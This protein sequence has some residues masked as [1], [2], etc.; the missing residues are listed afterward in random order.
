MPFKS[1]IDAAPTCHARPADPAKVRCHAKVAQHRPCRRE[2]SRP[3]SLE[4]P[5]FAGD[6]MAGSRC[7]SH[8]TLLKFSIAAR[9]T[10]AIGTHGNCCDGAVRTTADRTCRRIGQQRQPTA[11]VIISHSF[12]LQLPGVVA[13]RNTPALRCH[14]GK[15]GPAALSNFALVSLCLHTSRPELIE[16]LRVRVS[17]L[18]LVWSIPVGICLPGAPD[19]RGPLRGPRRQPVRRPERY[20]YDSD[21]AFAAMDYDTQSYFRC[22]CQSI[23]AGGMTGR[24]PPLTGSALA[25]YVYGNYRRG[26]RRGL[27]F[28]FQCSM[29]R[30]AT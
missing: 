9:P 10:T 22:H 5:A 24:H 29:A 11:I 27:E 25:T 20:E 16:R 23:L 18:L 12:M 26:T 6:V 28:R 2:S 15:P 1:V 7:E 17:A 8:G 21:A 14:S 30:T 13:A 4:V 3:L 19:L